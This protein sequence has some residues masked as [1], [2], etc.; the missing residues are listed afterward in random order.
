MFRATPGLVLRSVRFKNGL[1]DVDLEVPN[2]Q[3]LD[4]LKQNLM[5]S[6]K[7]EVEIQSAASRNNKVQGRLQIKGKAS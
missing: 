7:L 2:L 3:A 6:Q 1:L 5:N 4:Q